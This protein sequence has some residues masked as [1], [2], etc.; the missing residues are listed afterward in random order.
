[1]RIKYERCVKIL[2]CIIVGPLPRLS[3][4]LAFCQCVVSLSQVLEYGNTLFEWR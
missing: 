3:V 4:S 1:M 2:Y